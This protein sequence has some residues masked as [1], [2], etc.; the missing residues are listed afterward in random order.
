M[1]ENITYDRLAQLVSYNR[2]TGDF[3]WKSVRR[4]SS[5]RPGDR[6]GSFSPK[7]QSYYIDI[8]RKRYPLHNLAWFYVHRVWPDKQL[9]HRDGDGTNNAIANLELPKIAEAKDLTHER[10]LEVLDY[11]ADTGVFRWKIRASKRGKIGAVAGLGTKAGGYTYIGIDG[12]DYLAAR[13]AWLYVHGNWP[14]RT[15]RF[16]NRIKTDVRI[17]NL[18][19]GVWLDTEFDHKTPEGRSAYDKAFRRA[20]PDHVK[21]RDLRKNFGIELADYQRMFV[22]QKGVCA[23]CAKP[24]T[25]TRNGKAKWLAVDH[26]RDSGLIRGLLCQDC[27]LGIGHLHHST[28]AL[29][30]AIDYLERTDPAVTEPNVVRLRVKETS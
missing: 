29:R 5:A 17:A 25:R 21:E 16:Q 11:D 14:A 9:R 24:E 13:L 23:I 6:A 7:D 3:R 30:A 1:T 2:E 12:A 8:D 4:G 26:D 22:E 10:L 18:A 15:L 20:H 27:N 28:E 19:E